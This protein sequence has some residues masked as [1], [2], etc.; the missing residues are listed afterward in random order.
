MLNVRSISSCTELLSSR[1]KTARQKSGVAI[2]QKNETLLRKV[3][4]ITE[5]QLQQFMQSL[6]LH[7]I[8]VATFSV[9]D[10]LGRPISINWN[11]CRDFNTL[12]RILK[13]YMFNRL[14]VGADYVEWGDYNLVC[15]DG[16]IILRVDFPRAVKPGSQ[17]DMSIIKRHTEIYPPYL[18]S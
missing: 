5:T 9:V 17:F 11:H 15:L 1:Q 13:V 14:E 2:D 16:S 4:V 6:Q 12:D 18:V 8:S 10:P 7:D 3:L